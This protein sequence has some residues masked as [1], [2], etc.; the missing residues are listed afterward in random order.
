MRNM[1]LENHN[2]EKKISFRWSEIQNIGSMIKESPNL[3]FIQDVN[4]DT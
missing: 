3:S 4:G 2:E 1:S